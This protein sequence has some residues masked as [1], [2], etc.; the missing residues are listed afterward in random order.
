MSQP[1]LGNGLW[2]KKG[3][4]GMINDAQS[5]P[6]EKRITLF[7][8]GTACGERRIWV[9]YCQG[10]ALPGIVTTEEEYL[11]WSN[12]NGLQHVFP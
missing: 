7:G 4:T 1:R 12:E 2:R 5:I 9:K 10:P 8:K 11:M 3:R 6:I